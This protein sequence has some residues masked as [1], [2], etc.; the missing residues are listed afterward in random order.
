MDILISTQEKKSIMLTVIVEMMLARGKISSSVWT[1]DKIKKYLSSLID[2]NREDVDENVYML[3]LG[4]LKIVVA[5]ILVHVTGINKVVE[6]TDFIQKYDD[7]YKLVVFSS[8][9]DKA[10]T[11][12]LNSNNNKTHKLEIFTESDVSANILKIDYSPESYQLL[13]K[14]EIEEVKNKYSVDQTTLPGIMTTDPVVTFYD[15]KP[16]DI[17]RIVRRSETSCKVPTRRIVK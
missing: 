4:S 17:V 8:I 9:T 1:S 15:L 5:F 14:E 10:K 7:P 11:F 12:M 13:T 2:D 6:F 3:N 16:G